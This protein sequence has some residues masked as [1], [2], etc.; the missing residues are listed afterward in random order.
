MDE[1]NII[2][3]GRPV[4]ISFSGVDKQKVEKLVSALKDACI[5]YSY[6]YHNLPGAKKIEYERE[7]GYGEFVI[8]VFGKEYFESWDCMYEFAR[9]HKFRKLNEQKLVI[10]LPF[11]DDTSFKDSNKGLQLIK[12]IWNTR[13]QEGEE[14]NGIKSLAKYYGYYEKEIDLLP[15]YYK[16]LVRSKRDENFQPL[17]TKVKDFFEQH[18]NPI[19][20]ASEIFYKFDKDMWKNLVFR[21][22]DT[23]DYIIPDISNGLDS[24]DKNL[25]EKMI[26]ELDDNQIIESQPK[27][28]DLEINEKLSLFY[29]THQV[30]IDLNDQSGFHFKYYKLMPDSKKEYIDTVEDKKQFNSLYDCRSAFRKVLDK[31]IGNNGCVELKN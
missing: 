8:L 4:Y 6:M 16:N 7:I 28:K 15:S 2:N 11:D 17:I 26:E 21:P 3:K 31:M 18:P 9:V 13:K 29:W 30:Y 14:D 12:D 1:D 19:T 5:D 24:E 27:R 23:D 22:K 20:N 25:F 10:C